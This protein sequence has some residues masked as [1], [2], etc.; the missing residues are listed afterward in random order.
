MDLTSDIKKYISQS[1]LCWLATVDK[2]GTPNVSPKEIFDCHENKIILAN[3]A[4]PNTVKNIKSNENVCISFIDILVQKGF[5]LKGHARIVSEGEENYSE[6]KSILLKMTEGKFPFFTIT[7]II[8]NQ[9]KPII[10]PRYLLYPDTTEEEQIQS[11]K[12]QYK[13]INKDF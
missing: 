9:A 10:S 1:V 12:I 5:Q 4:S 2:T 13:M 3:I 8:I 6:Y 11:A 7:E